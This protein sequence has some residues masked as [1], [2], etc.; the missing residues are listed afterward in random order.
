MNKKDFYNQIAIL[1]NTTHTYSTFN[2]NLPVNKKTGIRFNTNATR[3]GPRTPGNGRFPG[4][5]IV[6]DF[7]SEILVNLHEPE[8]NGIFESREKALNAIKKTLAEKL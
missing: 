3:W 1:L 8:I 4:H 5:G 6:R 7:G 2:D